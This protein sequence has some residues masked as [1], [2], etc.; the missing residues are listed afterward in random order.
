VFTARYALSPY[1]KHIS[2]VFKGLTTFAN[3][4]MKDTK[5]QARNQNFSLGA[6]GRQGADSEA[7]YTP[8]LCLIFEIMLQ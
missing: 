8:N 4:T 5:N 7:I 3:L 2:F 1:I 6:V